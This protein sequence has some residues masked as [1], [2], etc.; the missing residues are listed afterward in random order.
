MRIGVHH[1]LFRSAIQFFATEEQQLVWAH[2]ADEYHILGAFAMTE[3]GHSSSLQDI[4]TTATLDKETDEWVL[5]S[6]TLT[7][8]KWWMGMVGQTSTHTVLLAQTIINQHEPSIGLNW[9]MV[10]LRDVSTGR[11]LPGVTCGD[12]GAKAGRNGIDNGFILLSQVRIPRT[13][14]LMRWCHCDKNGIVQGPLHPAVM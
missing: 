8:C 10:P 2:K 1:I 4:E 14:M 11:L 5:H 12:L 13:N 6:P 9:F 7:S 3:L